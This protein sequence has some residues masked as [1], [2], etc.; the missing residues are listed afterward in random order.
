MTTLL[1]VLISVSVGL[2]ALKVYL[3]QI[4]SYNI[5]KTQQYVQQQ[6]LPSGQM[7]EQ[8]V[9]NNTGA[10]YA[11]PNRIKAGNAQSIGG[12]DF[13]RNYFATVPCDG[14]LLAVVSDGLDDNESGR[15]AAI[16]AVEILKRN[17]TEGLFEEASPHEFF[18]AS[19]QMIQKSLKDNININQ[20]GVKLAAVV[21]GSGVLSYAAI[22]D[23]VLMLCR[24]KEIF[25]LT[26][27]YE[28]CMEQIPLEP[29]DSIVI[30][31]KGAF[32]GLT[33]TVLIWCLGLAEHPQEKC[34]KLLKL[35]QQ[36]PNL[37]DNLTIV[38]LEAP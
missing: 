16:I 24:N 1:V 9:P 15:L 27:N 26:E 8:E 32:E 14:R 22:G 38:V 10:F 36:K 21:M 34:H 4:A 17:F 19:F 13:Q 23:C 12:K 28:K 6:Y 31:S 33:E 30:A 2:I 5:D 3:W 18:E 25:Y 35:I 37:R 29:K 11:F 7:L 20:F